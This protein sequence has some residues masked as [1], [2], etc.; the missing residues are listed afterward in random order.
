MDSFYSRKTW[1]R[2]D[3]SNSAIQMMRRS[4]TATLV[5]R[6]HF[7][8][9]AATACGDGRTCTLLAV[10]RVLAAMRR[11]IVSPLRTISPPTPQR[12]LREKSSR[13]WRR[14]YALR[15]ILN[16]IGTTAIERLH[17]ASS[18]SC[19][20]LLLWSN[21]SVLSID[22]GSASSEGSNHRAIMSPGQPLPSFNLVLLPNHY[23]TCFTKS[24]MPITHIPWT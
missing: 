13:W 6:Y 16:G 7:S 18:G 3:G 17:G 24:F 8:L 12:F 4:W 21:I 23:K 1:M 20:S 15:K 14:I 10:T 22:Y 5:Q 2:G 9:M 11:I 19:C